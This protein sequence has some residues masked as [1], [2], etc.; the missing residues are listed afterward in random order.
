MFIGFE[1]R[2]VLHVPM[3][4]GDKKT[5][6]YIYS[7]HGWCKKKLTHDTWSECQ[8]LAE[9]LNILHPYDGSQIWP[10]S[11]I[12]K[13]CKVAAVGRTGSCGRVW[14][15]VVSPST[16]LSG[17]STGCT[18]GQWLHKLCSNTGMMWRNTDRILRKVWQ[19]YRRGQAPRS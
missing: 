6:I 15:A 18:S 5:I 16:V 10:N 14:H 9:P 4:I 11:W 2:L 8:I 19:K 12:Q 3:V 17:W 7:K 13:A 1:K